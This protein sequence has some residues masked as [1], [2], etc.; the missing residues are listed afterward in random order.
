MLRIKTVEVMYIYEERFI[1]NT[2]VDVTAKLIYFIY[3]RKLHLHIYL[4]T[5]IL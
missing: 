1:G 5:H 3:S 2:A 4:H